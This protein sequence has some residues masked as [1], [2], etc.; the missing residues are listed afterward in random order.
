M[1]T[2]S[3]DTGGDSGG[4]FGSVSKNY[5]NTQNWSNSFNSSTSSQ[6]SWD[7]IGNVAIG[8]DGSGLFND[9]NTGL[10]V[11][12]FGAVAVVALLFVVKGG[13]HG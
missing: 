4:L 7:R 8:S 12:L 5:A 10:Y 3:A 6:N 9:K 1:G 13:S 2:F 11:M